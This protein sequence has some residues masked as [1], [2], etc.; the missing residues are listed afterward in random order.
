MDKA[1]YLRW[2]AFAVLLSA[3]CGVSFAQTSDQAS[4]TS[5]RFEAKTKVSPGTVVFRGTVS[6]EALQRQG[7]THG[8]NPAT[9]IEMHKHRLPNGKLTSDSSQL[10]LK[11]APQLPQNVDV[12]SGTGGDGGPNIGGVMQYHGF[13]GIHDGDNVTA[14]GGEL[15]PPDQGLAVY[16]NQVAEINNDVVMFFN[17][18]TGAPLT[19]PISTASFFLTSNSVGDTQVFFDPTVQR[20]FFTEIDSN[21][22]SVEGFDVAVSQTPNPLGSYFVYF[23]RAFSSDLSGCG[24]LDCLPDYPKGGYDANGLYISADLFNASGPFVA[25]ATYAL[26][27]SKLIAGAGFTY[28][29]LTYPGDFVVQPSVPAPNVPFVTA[30]NGTEYLMEA[31]NIFDGSNNIRVWAISNTNNIVS[32]ISSLRGFGVD[33]AAEAYTGTTPSTE[34]NI[35]GPYCKSQGVTSAPLLD[36]GYNAFQATIQMTSTRLFGALAFDSPD[37]T[38]LA[39]DVIAWFAVTPSVNSSGV[40]SASIF[41]QGYVVPPTGYSI[42]YPAFGLNNLGTGVLGMTITNRF[43]TVPGG[44]PSAAF[45]Q[46]SAGAPIYGINVSGPGITSDDGFTGCPGPGPGQVG[47]WGDYAAAVQDARTLFWYTGNENISG[48]RGTFANWGTNITQVR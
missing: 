24:G 3:T 40:P 46:V 12:A 19:A 10:D 9:P 29:R 27:K 44:F 8:A 43:A 39:R 23:V 4:G 7:Y 42:S 35:V 11:A 47:R 5:P 25:A 33:I 37:S 26:P 48:T 38:G 30:A 36:G 6:I 14:N 13:T 31:R 17:G 45:M 28:L 34:P 32:N 1:F 20:W 21:F 15:E 22:G 2:S 16:N 41:R 18:T